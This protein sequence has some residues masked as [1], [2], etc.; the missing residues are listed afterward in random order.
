MFVCSMTLTK[1]KKGVISTYI[2]QLGVY[3]SFERVL[4]INNRLVK[5]I[6]RLAYCT[7]LLVMFLPNLSFQGSV[8]N[9]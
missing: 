4:F 3:P 6:N 2:L 9:L 7:G 8:N 1:T 5:G